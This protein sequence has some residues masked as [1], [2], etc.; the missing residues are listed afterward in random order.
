MPDAQHVDDETILDSDVLWRRVPDWPSFITF[1]KQRG[2][3]RVTSSAFDNDRDGDPM[4]V[5]LAAITRPDDVLAGH[6]G[7]GIVA[8]TAGFV[9]AQGQMVFR[10]PDDGPPGHAKVAGPK[11]RR[12]RRAFAEVARWVRRPEPYDQERLP[13]PPEPARGA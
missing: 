12:V 3:Y 8:F 11:D 1:D 10:S 7:F 13:D 2:H 5:F 9:R 6:D 4:S